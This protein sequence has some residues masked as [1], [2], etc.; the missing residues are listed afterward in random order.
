MPIYLICNQ[1]VTMSKNII[2]CTIMKQTIVRLMTA[3]HENYWDE[4]LLN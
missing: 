2:K 3:L 1:N 4:S